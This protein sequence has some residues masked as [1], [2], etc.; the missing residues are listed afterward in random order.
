MSKINRRHQARQKQQM[1]HEQNIKSTSIF[2]G[3]NGAPRIVAVVPLCSDGDAASAI[4]KL[5]RGFDPEANVS[6]GGVT[7][8]RIDRFKQNIAYIPIQRDLLSALDACRVADFVVFL[9]SPTQEPDDAGEM[10]LRAIEGQGV[11]NVFT[12]VQNLDKIEPPKKRSQVVTSLKLYVTHFFPAQEK[13]HSL[14][15]E[16]ECDNIIRSL[17]T[18][19]PKGVGWR[20][21]RSWMLVESIAWPTENQSDAQG[22][23]IITGVV[24]GRGL[25]ANRLVQVGDWGD[26]Q[27]EKITAA[28]LPTS[29][30]R[31]VDEMMVDTD[32]KGEVIL[33]IPDEDQDNL[34]ELAPDE[35]NMDDVDDLA[36]SEAPTEKRGVLLDD[37]HY[38]SDDETHLPDAPKR[39]P[40]GT[41]SY[42][43][44]WFLGD[45]SDS[46]SDTEEE[47]DNDGDL[48]MDTPA[49]PQDGLEGLTK[50]TQGACTE[51]GLSEYPE[52]E[53]FLDPSP[54][55]EAAQLAAYRSQRKTKAKEDLEFPD[56]IE[57]YP[58]VLAR[59]RL[60][61]YRGL[62]S[63]RTSRWE[64]SE[65]KAH[66]PADWTRLLQIPDYRKALKHTV[67]ETLI[68]GVQPGTRVNIHL[69][70]VPLSLQHH[71]TASKPLA[72]FSLLRHEHKHT[73]LNITITLPSTYPAPLKSK[74]PLLLQCGPRR[75]AITPLFSQ[76]GTNPN[77]IH[78]YIRYLH[79][80]QTA[81]ATF[82]GPLTWGTTPALFFL[83][84]AP[85]ATT[86]SPTPTLIATGTTT[87]PSQTRIIAKRI[88]LTGH[89]FKIHKKL[90]TVRYMFF[91]AEDV[92][93]FKALQ[94][95]TRRGRSGFV[96]ES[97]GT[98]GYFKATFDR[99]VN[100]QD[101]VGVSLYK[102]VWPRG[103][104]R[105]GGEGSE[106]GGGD[107]GD[108]EGGLVVGS[109][110]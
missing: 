73:T 17:C 96:K 98:H 43:A 54:S 52:S 89:P 97:L 105:W 75:H 64:T 67:R 87:P 69:R 95:W 93:W 44:A 21:N 57:L 30:K 7:E 108:G 72:L 32:T 11:S 5:N 56:E 38:F 49:L 63:L 48:V 71:P 12:M 15:S 23:A 1:K 68:G 86:P 58:N 85:Q 55:D 74:Q 70:N 102:R 4:D 33:E 2:S 14:D 8:V 77:N 6:I 90:V 27:I 51:G 66:E 10:I 45:M 81:M 82:T 106:V 50:L 76:T 92:N 46:G 35:V 31:K 3:Q 80:G 62:K 84:S 20:E 36:V 100:P 94:L 24:R 59:E 26:F 83:P 42:Q 47:L 37:H 16:R 78:K 18:T 91:N 88:I 103:C 65:D 9:L 40:K 29:K 19:S 99:G 13:V 34:T 104:G 110:I 109:G 107:A 53:M 60:A 101:A 79:P 28:P 22:E 61:R 39:L 25:R 41:S